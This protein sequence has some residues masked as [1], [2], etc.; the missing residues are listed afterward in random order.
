MIRSVTMIGLLVICL[1]NL[2]AQPSPEHVTVCLDVQPFVEIHPMNSGILAMQN[3]DVSMFNSVSLGSSGV[4][5]IEIRTNCRATLK[6][7]DR[8]TLTRQDAPP[9]GTYSVD[10]SLQ[11]GGLGGTYSV[12][13]GDKVYQCLDI[14]PG[15]YFGKEAPVLDARL[16]RKTWTSADAAGLY[17]G[18][19]RLELAAK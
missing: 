13:V 16:S 2:P 6:C 9:E 11:W 7:L 18:T 1:Q 5:G 4:L 3:I 14:E 19:I 15:C 10:A 17:T 12:I 8:V